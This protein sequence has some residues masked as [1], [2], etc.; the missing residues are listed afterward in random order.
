MKSREL[1]PRLFFKPYCEERE[2]YTSP[3]GHLL[4]QRVSIKYIRSF[5]D[6]ID[7]IISPSLDGEIAGGFFICLN[8]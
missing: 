5:F 6:R 4:K 8:V 1:Q 3:G 7:Q 2:E